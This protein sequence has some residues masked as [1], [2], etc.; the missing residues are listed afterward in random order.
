MKFGKKTT[1]FVAV[2]LAF[3]MTAGVATLAKPSPT[4]K[5]VESGTNKRKKLGMTGANGPSKDDF[6]ETGELRA[7]EIGE[8]RGYEEFVDENG[9]I[10]WEGLAG[11]ND[12]IYAW[13]EIPGTTISYPIVQRKH[14]GTYAAQKFYVTH[15][16]DGKE[17]PSGAIFT[18]YPASLDF[19]DRATPLYGHDMRDGSMFAELH[20]YL[21]E[22][23]ETE[24]EP[25]ATEGETNEERKP[26]EAIVRTKDSTLRFRIFAAYR[27]NAAHLDYAYENGDVVSKLSDEEEVEK[28]IESAKNPRS[29]K[30]R[31]FDASDV[32]PKK[33][34]ILTLC[35]CVPDDE[36]G[37][38]L[39]QAV[40][41]DEQKRN[42]KTESERTSERN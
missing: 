25:G 40:L 1:A 2:I 7:P 37:R 4:G 32:D 14:D 29:M 41:I 15:G 34:R 42:E 12:E 38:L 26:L 28:Y 35:T 11:F 20:E 30:S 23:A 39:I 27:T 18:Q 3:A 22:P 9:E 10:D 31:T 24:S 36:N 33:S 6:L 5:P 17:D 13:I 19:S 16:Y 21:D 8:K